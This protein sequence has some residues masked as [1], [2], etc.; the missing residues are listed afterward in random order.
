MPS[1]GTNEH[2]DE[3]GGSEAASGSGSPAA[4][5]RSTAPP[6]LSRSRRF[7]RSM[8]CGAMHTSPKNE[9]ENTKGPL[10]ESWASPRKRASLKT[11]AAWDCL[12][13]VAVSAD[14]IVHD[15]TA[16]ALD[17]DVLARPQR[18]RLHPL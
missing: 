15:V 16:R 4:V 12:H 10:R 2:D 5:P 6:S 11:A 7:M 17:L 8:S 18:L 13:G 14:E 1:S 9:F 3:V